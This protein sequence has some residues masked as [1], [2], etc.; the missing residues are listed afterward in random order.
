[1]SNFLINPY[2]SFPADDCTDIAWNTGAASGMVFSTTTTTNDTCT[3][4]SSAGTKWSG[5]DLSGNPTSSKLTAC[6]KFSANDTDDYNMPTFMP[7]NSADT[8]ISGNS[9]GAY[10]K[11][12]GTVAPYSGTADET[13]FS[14]DAGDTI[15][16]EIDTE[17]RI[18]KNGVLQ[19]TWDETP[20]NATYYFQTIAGTQTGTATQSVQLV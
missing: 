7:T 19:F 16:M 20:S 1:M 9:F 8:W 5:T 4:A 6:F 3:R 18:Y 13:P 2:I 15:K 11:N 17:A 12:N 14:A 10:P